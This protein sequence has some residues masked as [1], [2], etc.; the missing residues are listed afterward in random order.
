MPTHRSTERSHERTATR[1]IKAVEAP[2]KIGFPGA[3][4]VLQ[5]RRTVTRQG[6]RSVEIVAALRNLAISLLRLAGSTNIAQATRHTSRD[7]TRAAKL[8]LTS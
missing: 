2:A 5:L 6:K 3:R 4:Q 7:V 1:T 8:I